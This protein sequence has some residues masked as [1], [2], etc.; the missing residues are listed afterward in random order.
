MSRRHSYSGACHCGNLSLR[1]DSDK[2]PLELGL[3]TDTCSF[4]TKHQALYTADPGGELTLVAGDESRIERYHFGTKTAEFII[5]R[6]CGVFVAAYMAEPPLGVVNVN[7]LEQR[8]EF[9]ANTL[10]VAD[11]D[12]EPVADRLA[13]RCAKW[14]PVVSF[15][16]RGS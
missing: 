6:T 4:C 5:C 9:L 2:T 13:R 14:T 11:L 10:Q 8:A 1:L 16:T 15:T 12:G 7:V 3:R